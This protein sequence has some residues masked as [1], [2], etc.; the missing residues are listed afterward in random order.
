MS[1]DSVRAFRFV[2]SALALAALGA[3]APVAAE[4]TAGDCM[5]F[6]F[7]AGRPAVISRVDGA[8]AKAFFVRSAWE[9]AACPADTMA[10]R[11]RAYLVPGDL[12]LT[13]KVS[14]VYTC[15]AFQALNDRKQIW[16]NGWIASARLAPVAPA[17]AT[18]SSDWTGTWRHTGGEITIKPAKG[19]KLSVAGEHTYPVAG[20]VRTGDFAADVAPAG[21]VL[22]FVDGG[23]KPFD[24][25][26]EDECRV[27]MQRVGA[28]L[29]VE[30]NGTCGGAMV[31]FTGL[32]QRKR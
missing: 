9:N 32:Y 26:A 1:F 15:V 3:A 14:G 4:E 12:V 18:Q 27:R 22:A 31:T 2:G 13:G 10:C 24:K 30:D 28:I 8:A 25:A 29:V 11:G 5:G 16:T 6:D 23:D 19:G 21:G 7:D 20:N 17:S